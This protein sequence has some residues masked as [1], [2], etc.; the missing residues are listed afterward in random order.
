MFLRGFFIKKYKRKGVDAEDNPQF[1]NKLRKAL[2]DTS[3]Q[4]MSLPQEANLGNL[5]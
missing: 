5:A 1:Q 2:S 3:N 4:I